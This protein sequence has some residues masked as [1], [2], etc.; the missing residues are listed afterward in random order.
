MVV[1][2]AEGRNFPSGDEG[3]K[4]VRG[5]RV[6]G[7]GRYCC[8]GDKRGICLGP[9]RQ[10]PWGE[11]R[12]PVYLPCVLLETFT[13]GFETSFI[14]K[15]RGKREVWHNKRSLWESLRP[16]LISRTEIISS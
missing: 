10:P 12:V 9:S 16:F 13:F 7:E 3:R 11:E 14:K 4:G 8:E 5:W 1:P 6:E 2:P 15:G